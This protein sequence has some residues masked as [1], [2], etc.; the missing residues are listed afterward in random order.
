MKGH[1]MVQ[2]ADHCEDTCSILE[3]LLEE[4][5]RLFGHDVM[6]NEDCIV[7]N[8]PQAECPMLIKNVTPIK[9]RLAQE[10]LSYWSQ[11]VYQLSHEMCH[12]A[13]RQRKAK[14]D[15]TLSWFEEIVCG[16]ISLYAMEYASKNWRKCRLSQ[17]SPAFY[18]AHQSYLEDELGEAFTDGLK[19]CNTVEKL[20]EYESQ[21]LAESR[22]ETYGAERILAYKAI[23]ARPLEVRCVL[24]Y[25]RYIISNGV[26]IDFDRW[27][28]EN[29]CSLLCKLKTI[30]PVK[31]R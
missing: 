26:V 20:T 7:Y 10:S 14:K 22:R 17:N 11:T 29:P 25:T 3:F 30:Q 13:N 4:F 31:I 12:Y 2:K 8:D 18:E 21:R 1:W 5:D 28:R 27:I 23:S 24:D 16:A 9:I 15:F 19:R 6:F